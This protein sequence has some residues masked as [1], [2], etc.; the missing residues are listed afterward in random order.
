[1]PEQRAWSS[2]SLVILNRNAFSCTTSI[3]YRSSREQ[4]QVGTDG[5]TSGSG[6]FLLRAELSSGAGSSKTW[7]CGKPALDAKR[8][9]LKA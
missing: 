1:M 7:R 3:A 8:E 9:V 6:V 2:V 5:T 4:Y